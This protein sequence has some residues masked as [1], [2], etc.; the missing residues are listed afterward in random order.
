MCPMPGFAAAL[1]TEVDGSVD[2]MMRSWLLLSMLLLLLRVSWAFDK[3]VPPCCAGRGSAENGCGCCSWSVC[4]S[5]VMS[6]AAVD[7]DA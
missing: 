3:V 2:A 7:D 1:S 5:D 4:P 6:A